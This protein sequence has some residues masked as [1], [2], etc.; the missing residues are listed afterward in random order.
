M[1]NDL[2]TGGIQAYASL[3]GKRLNAGLVSV[4]SKNTRNTL[5]L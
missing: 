2:K 4:Q 3:D 1:R 5:G